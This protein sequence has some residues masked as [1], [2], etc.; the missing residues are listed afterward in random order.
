M[1]TRTHTGPVRNHGAGAAARRGLGQK[2]RAAGRAL[3]AFAD[4]FS[5]YCRRVR[6]YNDLTNLN[7]QTL[8]DIGRRPDELARVIAGAAPHRERHEP[9]AGA[10]RTD[11]P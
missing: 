8:H 1:A 6:A 3:L 9:P 5:G 10:N 2:V 4:A 11:I 7:P